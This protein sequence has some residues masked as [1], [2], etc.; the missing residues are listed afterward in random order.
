[1]RTI[2]RPGTRPRHRLETPSG[3]HLEAN[4]DGALTRFGA[5]DL[6]LLLNPATSIEAGAAN[7]HLRVLGEGGE[8]VRRT[9]LLGQDSP[10]RVGIVDDALV[11]AGTWAGLDY[12]LAL[13]LGAG[14]PDLVVGP[15]G[16]QPRH[17]ARPGRRR[18]HPRP[19]AGTGGR[20]RQQPVLRQP[21]P[22]RD[23]GRDAGPRRRAGRA[24][25]HARRAGAVGRRRVL[26]PRSG[27]GDRRAPARLPHHDRDRV[28]RPRPRPPVRAAPARAHAGRPAG[29]AGRPR[30][31]RQPP[32]RLRRP[33]GGGPPRGDRSRRRAPRRHRPGLYAP[34]TPAP[35]SQDSST[36]VPLPARR[37]CWRP[38]PCWRAS[39]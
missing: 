1:M 31:G 39:P 22:R 25:E 38:H 17:V 24:A 33:R 12:S 27:L 32:H 3:M 21:V 18:A 7:V 35:P 8:V 9:P 37:P 2:Q 23:P 16:G 5:G 10:S 6:S 13:T 14:R 29:R 19:G 36:S 11:A 34:G 30:A 28:V 20:G 26:R 4:A 15:R